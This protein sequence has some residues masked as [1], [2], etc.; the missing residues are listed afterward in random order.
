MRNMLDALGGMALRDSR[1][2]DGAILGMGVF[3]SGV[4]L[5]AEALVPARVQ[6][7]VLSAPLSVAIGISLA[8]YLWI[9]FRLWRMS[10]TLPGSRLLF[11]AFVSGILA[12]AVWL[13]SALASPAFRA[14]V[15]AGR[16]PSSALGLALLIFAGAGSVLTC[17][18]GLT[19]A[20]GLKR[21]SL[22]RAWV[23]VLG[24]A[25]AGLGLISSVA[26]VVGPQLVF[27]SPD[28]GVLTRGVLTGAWLT[29]IASSALSIAFFAAI[30]FA[31]FW[32]AAA[33]AEAAGA[34]HGG[35]GI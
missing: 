13:G 15:A 25:A 23:A 32:T 27:S 2:V 26:P 11:I 3:A 16:S 28:Y 29:G 10:Q 22:V 12:A 9:E 1:R 5:V 35:S 20:L 21:A 34:A 31:L 14:A 30:G 17:V 19:L 8:A 18:E 33:G 7:T 24:V 6:L 4:A